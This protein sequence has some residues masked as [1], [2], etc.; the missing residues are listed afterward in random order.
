[1]GELV[2]GV[3]VPPSGGAVVFVDESI[4][5]LPA[6]YLVDGDRFRCC[7]VDAGGGALVDAAVGS[8]GVVVVEELEE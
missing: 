2:G 5:Y 7:L 1:L 8:V 3:G 4:K 6:A